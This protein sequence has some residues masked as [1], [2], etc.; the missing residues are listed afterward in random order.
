MMMCSSVPWGCLALVLCAVSAP[1]NQRN[2]AGASQLK[3]GWFLSL[4]VAEFAMLPQ[5]G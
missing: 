5:S 2:G 3:L 4:S 1:G